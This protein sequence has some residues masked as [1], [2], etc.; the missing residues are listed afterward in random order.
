MGL[1]V[2]NFKFSAGKFYFGVPR[3]VPQNKESRNI[4]ISSIFR[5]PKKYWDR[6]EA[7]YKLPISL[8]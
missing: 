2:L 1:Y 6:L 4:Y 5:D 8:P 7:P 3:N